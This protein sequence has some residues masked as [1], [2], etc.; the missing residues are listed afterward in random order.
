MRFD[1]LPNICG[2]LL[3]TKGEN[4]VAGTPSAPEKLRHTDKSK[5]TIDLA[6]QAPRSDGGSP[7]RGYYVEKMRSDGTEFEVANRKIFTE[8][9]GTVENLS[10]DQD[11]QFRVK[12]VNEVGEGE[13]SKP[14]SARI[15]DHESTNCFF[16]LLL[17]FFKICFHT[18]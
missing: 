12:A 5:T 13:P 16:F 6:W 14:I 11:Y 1:Q 7:I 3:A 17:T 15:Q 2:I 8:C 10:E 18:F 9:C 4:S